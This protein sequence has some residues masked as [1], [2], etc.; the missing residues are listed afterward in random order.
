[1]C[2]PQKIRGD[3]YLLNKFDIEEQISEH[4]SPGV[5]FKL[6]TGYNEVNGWLGYVYPKELDE[7]DKQT[8]FAAIECGYYSYCPYLFVQQLINDEVFPSGNYII[9]LD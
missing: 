1:M 3:V 9:Y 2:D 4:W 5:P 6:D 7:W 8:V